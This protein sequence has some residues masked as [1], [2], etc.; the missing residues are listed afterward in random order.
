MPNH[1]RNRL[2]NS[3]V[4]TARSIRLR[5]LVTMSFVSVR[6]TLPFL[7]NRVHTRPFLKCEFGEVC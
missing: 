4:L 7:V 6:V 5:P 1:F 3:P 2:S